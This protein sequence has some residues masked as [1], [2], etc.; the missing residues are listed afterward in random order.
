MSCWINTRS[1]RL[2]SSLRSTRSKFYND[3]PI[4]VRIRSITRVNSAIILMS[5]QVNSTKLAEKIFNASKA[6][7]TKR[8]SRYSWV[9]FLIVR[10][11]TDSRGVPREARCECNDQVE[12]CG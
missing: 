5:H 3:D 11:R 9:D 12:M 6:S 1:L 4:V 8:F 10:I 7:H 2:L